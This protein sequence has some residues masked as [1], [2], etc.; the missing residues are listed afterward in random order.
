M[1]NALA[2][3]VY[4]FQNMIHVYIHSFLENDHRLPSIFSYIQVVTIFSVDM[5]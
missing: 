1:K 3:T 4:K 5:L 2:E